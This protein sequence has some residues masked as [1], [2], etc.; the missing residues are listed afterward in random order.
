M[1]VREGAQSHN[2]SGEATLGIL[3]RSVSWTKRVA[4][5]IVVLV[6]LALA[7]VGLTPQLAEASALGASSFGPQVIWKQVTLPLGTY[8]AYVSGSGTYVSYVKGWPYLN[9]PVGNVCNWNVTA[10][11]FDSS[12]R[13]YRTLTG[14]THFTCNSYWNNAS[15]D[16]LW[17]NGYMKSGTMCSTLKQ[18]GAR[19]TSVCHSI[20]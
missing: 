18:N 20:H 16:Y 10:E 7:C 17:V 14:P 8:Y 15:P 5:R 6:S 19:L 12:G 1:L 11:F 4:I 2:P 3:R 13:W 9:S